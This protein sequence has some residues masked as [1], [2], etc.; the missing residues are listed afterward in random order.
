MFAAPA[1]CT[2]LPAPSATE[3][4]LDRT[5]AVFVQSEVVRYDASAGAVPT[6]AD[7]E[8]GRRSAAHLENGAATAYPA[9]SAADGFA[10]TDRGVLGWLSAGTLYGLTAPDKIVQ[11]DQG[12]TLAGLHAEG[13]ALVWTH[14]GAPRRVVVT[15]G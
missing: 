6:V 4:G 5:W 10:V 14:D 11:L 1:H 13:D 8:T 12:G 15:P 9:P 7:V 3:V 2:P